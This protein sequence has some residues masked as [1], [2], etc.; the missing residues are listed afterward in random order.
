MLFFVSPAVVFPGIE[1]LPPA[2]QTATDWNSPAEQPGGT[3][4]PAQLPHT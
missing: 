2:A 1:Q 4:P 3:F